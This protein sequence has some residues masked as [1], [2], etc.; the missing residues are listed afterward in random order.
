VQQRQ[1]AAAAGTLC[2]G[3]VDMAGDAQQTHSGRTKRPYIE[4]ALSALTDRAYRELRREFDAGTP[5]WA[6]SEHCAALPWYI[7]VAAFPF[8]GV[9]NAVLQ[10]AAP[11]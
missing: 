6:S 2:V 8:V 1:P 7:Q 3:R 5:D 9:A 4:N 10:H 11:V